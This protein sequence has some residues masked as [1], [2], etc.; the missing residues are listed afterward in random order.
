ML[1]QF[2]HTDVMLTLDIVTARQA[3]GSAWCLDTDVVWFNFILHS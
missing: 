3:V 1:G 2:T